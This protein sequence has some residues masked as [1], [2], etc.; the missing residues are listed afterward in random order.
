MARCTSRN[1]NRGDSIIPRAKNEMM[2]KIAV[3]IEIE[4]EIVRGRGERRHERKTNE[5]IRRLADS[6]A[7]RGGVAPLQMAA[8]ATKKDKEAKRSEKM[9]PARMETQKRKSE[10][11]ENEERKK[12][13][14]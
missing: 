9:M 14:K 2:R 13:E 3:E 10:R 12:E 11:K 5:I 1:S 4:M 8:S 7:A 6:Q